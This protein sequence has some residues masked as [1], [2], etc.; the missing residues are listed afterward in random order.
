MQVFKIVDADEWH[1]AEAQGVYRG[2]AAD[3]RDGFIHL[4]TSEQLARTLT[5]HFPDADNLLLVAF[6]SD[7]LGAA[8]KWENS[9][10]ED[11]FPHLYGDLDLKL[12]RWTHAIAKKAAGVYALP[13][14]AFVSQPEPPKRTN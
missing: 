4:S 13:V 1:A 2:S 9:G 14:Q 10:D 12:V 6:D 11:D 7:D 5:R 3:T 8:L